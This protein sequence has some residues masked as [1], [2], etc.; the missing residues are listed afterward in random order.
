M[1][2]VGTN[3][4]S[5][6]GYLGGAEAL[7][8]GTAG[9]EGVTAPSTLGINDAV[10]GLRLANTL[11]GQQQQPQ[12]GMFRQQVRPQGVVDYSPTLSLL[13]TQAR[14]PNIYSLLG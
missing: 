8:A 14:K 12:Q 9:I 13:Q 6:L 10:R 11:F 2:T 3:A 7:P 5:G 4:A 1:G